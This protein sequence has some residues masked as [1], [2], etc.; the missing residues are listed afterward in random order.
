[1]TTPNP[2]GKPAPGFQEF[3]TMLQLT[4]CDISKIS[5]ACGGKDA[6]SDDCNSLI[7]ACAS[8]VSGL[9]CD[10]VDNFVDQLSSKVASD[11]LSKLVSYWNTLV[12]SDSNS[13]WKAE[14]TGK[15]IGR[16]GSNLQCFANAINKKLPK[17]V[18]KANVPSDAM[19]KGIREG[20]HTITKKAAALVIG[21]GILLM[22]LLGV[23]VQMLVKN[24]VNLRMG[25][26]LGIV[27]L[28]GVLMIVCVMVSKM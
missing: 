14:D 15:F 10:N 18:A 11:D 21:S 13:D 2:N 25:L 8:Q 12:S 5:D 7:K 3:L 27:I 9:D 1:M 16:L 24:N 26:K 22:I 28:I 6:T 20:Q 17:G 19:D 4:N 23:V